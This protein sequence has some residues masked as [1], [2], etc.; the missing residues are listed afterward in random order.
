MHTMLFAP[1]LH[2]RVL[3]VIMSFI[4]A[5]LLCFLFSKE[6]TQPWRGWGGLLC[7]VTGPVCRDTF[8]DVVSCHVPRS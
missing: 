5:R 8:L 4:A 6:L 2:D 1:R 7:R 3:H